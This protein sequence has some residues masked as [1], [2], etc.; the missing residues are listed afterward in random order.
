MLGSHQAYD[1]GAYTFIEIQMLDKIHSVHLKQVG[2]S[3]GSDSHRQRTQSYNHDCQT[4][5]KAAYSTFDHLFTGRTMYSVIT[6]GAQGVNL[7]DD[8]GTTQECRTG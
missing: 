5:N 7:N 2:L 6:I 3:D 4:E 1:A 8:G